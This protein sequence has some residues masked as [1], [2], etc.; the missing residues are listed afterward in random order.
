MDVKCRFR[1]LAFEYPAIEIILYAQPLWSEV[2]SLVIWGVISVVGDYFGDH[3]GAPLKLYSIR[4]YKTNLSQLGHSPLVSLF[5]KVK[6]R[7]I[8]NKKNFEYR[9]KLHRT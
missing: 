1:Q 2:I 6:F 3:L 9:G 7:K 8:G 5:L 4:L